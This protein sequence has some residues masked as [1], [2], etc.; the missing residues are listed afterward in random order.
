MSVQAFLKGET[1]ILADEA[2]QNAVQSYHDVFLKS[3]RVEQ[4]VKSGACSHHDFREVFRNNIEKRVRFGMLGWVSIRHGM[5]VELLIFSLVNAIIVPLSCGCKWTA[6]W[7][8][9]RTPGRSKCYWL[10]LRVD[11]QEFIL[12]ILFG[13]HW[14]ILSRLVHSNLYGSFFIRSFQTLIRMVFKWSD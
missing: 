10:L 4:M 5:K 6:D 11:R 1:Q 7:F 8:R 2:F 14:I 13:R 3:E 9:V 12:K